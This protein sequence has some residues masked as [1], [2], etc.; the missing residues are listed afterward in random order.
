MQEQFHIIEIYVSEKMADIRR[1]VEQENLV[2]TA[3]SAPI[4]H[5]GWII[6]TMHNLS[7]WMIRTGERLHT[8]YHTPAHLPHLHNGSTQIR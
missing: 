5:P 8:R 7:I 3:E 1:E 4:K 2:R 6:N